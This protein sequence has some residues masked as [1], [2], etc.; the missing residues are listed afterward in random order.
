MSRGDLV[1]VATTS[2][3]FEG[4]LLA[5]VNDLVILQTQTVEVAINIA[6]LR[7]VRNDKPAWFEGSSGERSASSFRAMLGSY[8]VDAR[9][10]RL[11]GDGFDLTA[12][13]DAST[14]DHVLV[15]DEQGVEWAL[16]RHR[17]DFVM[18]PTSA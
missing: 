10:V 8:E 9:P 11:V 5:A 1:T 7:F 18:A 13:I 16:P 6:A 12:V 14:D 15:R 17:I 4:R 2:T 3:Q